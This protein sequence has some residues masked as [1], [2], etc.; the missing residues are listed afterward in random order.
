M[1]TTAR[2]GTTVLQI[3]AE[4]TVRGSGFVERGNSVRI[5]DAVVNDLPSADGKTITFRA[6]EPVEK[7]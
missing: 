1:L 3:L 6:P 7:T 4:H 5:G 2:G